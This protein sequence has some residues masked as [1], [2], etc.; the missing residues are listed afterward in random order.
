MP[1]RKNY[2]DYWLKQR[3]NFTYRY[4]PVPRTGKC[5]WRGQ[6]RHV[7]TTQEIRE[8]EFLAYDQEALDHGIRP[9]KYRVKANLPHL[10][11]DPSYARRGRG[12]KAHR[13]TQ[14]KPK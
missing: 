10:Y 12:W 14:W 2:Y 7:K 11:E 13:K 8:N 9:R 6:C 5:V 4:D 3:H 1:N